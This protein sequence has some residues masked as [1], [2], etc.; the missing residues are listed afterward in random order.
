V[1]F[2]AVAHVAEHLRRLRSA[3]DGQRHLLVM[4]KSMNAL[5]LAGADLWDDERIRRREAGGDLYFHRP[6]PPVLA[7][8]Q[9]TGFAQRLGADHVFPDKRSAI[10]TI[11]PRL[12]PDICARCQ[13][14]LFEECGERPG[15]PISPSI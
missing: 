13:V 15:A 7:M 12:D 9:H 10:A 3:P 5:D 11:V 2:G 6:R 4:A 1:W 14:R 8:W